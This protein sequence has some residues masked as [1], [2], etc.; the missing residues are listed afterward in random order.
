[1]LGRNPLFVSQAALLD[2]LTLT[3]TFVGGDYP[4]I[5]QGYVLLQTGNV[6]TVSTTDKT[7]KRYDP[8]L[9]KFVQ[10]ANLPVMLGDSSEEIGPGI[11]MMD[12]RVIW[13]GATG[14]TCIY[15]PGPKGQNGNWTQ[16]PDLPTMADG[17]QL[18]CTDTSDSPDR[19]DAVFGAMVCTGA[20]GAITAETL[21]WIKFGSPQCSIL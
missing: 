3:W 19:A 10:D 9:K 12:G 17:T 20:G 16:G 21:K 13:F 2:A 14:H 1:M 18:T 11:T 15:I 6:L 4:Y 8:S 7:S 5:E